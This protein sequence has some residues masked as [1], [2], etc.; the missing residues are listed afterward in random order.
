[1][2]RPDCEPRITDEARAILNGRAGAGADLLSTV[3]QYIRRYV[4]L[5]GIAYLPIALW[6]IATHAAERFDCFPYLALMSATKRSG[7]TRLAEVLEN[8]VHRPWRATAPSPAALYRMLEQG[9]TLLLDEVEALNGK[10]KS[11]TTQILLAALNAGHRKGDTISRCEG[12]KHDVRQFHVY[13]P[14]LFAAI[15]RLPDTLMDRSIII[16]MKRRLKTQ[17]V[18]RFRQVRA[19]SEARPIRDGIEGFV[20]VQRVDIGRAYQ[21]V[22]DAD[23]EYLNDRDADLWTPLFVICSAAD[24]KRLAELKTS[25]LSLSAAKAGDDVDD[26]YALTLLRDIR[27][28]WPDGEEKLETAI[29]LKRLKELEES[30]WGFPPAGEHQLTAHKLARMLRPFEIEPRNIQVGYRR[31]KG[32]HFEELKDVF[33]RYLDGKSATSATEQ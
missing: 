14:K 5:P 22:L 16:H 12:P 6:V 21:S 10:N 23:L 24:S 28:V 26:S 11:E 18:E 2:A 33:D 19:S 7:K 20:Q 15:G 32:Y 1:M 3:E 8:L 9:P 27:S 17:P 13:G 25:A 31:P 30:P 29:L 4:V